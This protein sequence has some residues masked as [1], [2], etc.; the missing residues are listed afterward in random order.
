[1]ADPY[2]HRKHRMKYKLGY[3]AE[4]AARGIN[5]VGGDAAK[6]DTRAEV[7]ARDDASEAEKHPEPSYKPADTQ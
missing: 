6:V 7:E 5:H 3:G 1:M 4:G 2:S